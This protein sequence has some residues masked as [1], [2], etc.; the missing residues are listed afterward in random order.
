MINTVDAPQD[1]PN[2]SSAQENASALARHYEG[3]GQSVEALRLGLKNLKDREVYV[4]KL[5]L[6]SPNAKSVEWLLLSKAY[7]P[8]GPRIAFTSGGSM[9]SALDNFGRRLRGGVVDWV[10]DNYPP[11]DWVERLAH[12]VKNQT[13][14]VY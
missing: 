6:R 5:E 12:I 13:W 10:D 2:G 14:I 11:D 7:T 4:Y 3:V 8:E 9:Y 1:K